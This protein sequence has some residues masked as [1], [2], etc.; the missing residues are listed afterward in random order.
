MRF[1]ET[2]I[3]ANAREGMT[4]LEY[5][6][7]THGARKGL[8]DTALKTADSGYLT[9]KLADVAQNVFISKTD[10]GTRQGISKHAIYKGE[11]IDIPLSEMIIGRI[12][13]ETITNPVTDQVIVEASKII[14]VDAASQIENLGIDTVTVRSPLTCDSSHGICQNCYGQD[15][16]TGRIVEEGLAVGIV[17]AQSIGEPGTQLTMRTFH[18]GGVA[19]TST[20]E[21]SYK[22]SQAGTIE[23]RD[24]NEVP[25]VDENGKD[26][27]VTL[28]RNGEIYV[29]DA[30][31]RELEKFKVQYGAFIR[32]EKWSKNLVQTL[33]LLTG[34]PTLRRFWQK[35][36]VRFGLRILK[37][38]KPFVL[39]LRKIKKAVLS[40]LLSSIKA[41][42]TPRIV[43]EGED[44]KILDFH[45]LPAKARIDVTEGLAIKPGQM[46]ARQ[47]REA[48]G[49][50]D[51]VGGLPRVTEIFEARKP[52]DAAVMAEISGVV[53]LK[54]DRRKGKMTITVK[55][56]AG[57]EVEQSRS[58]G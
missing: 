8:A 11:E 33:C 2:P 31:G 22:S 54:S 36:V 39:S 45:Y 25:I 49:S 38:V 46:L 7:S 34:T 52:K 1:I 30:K 23:I 43:I 58:S 12:S 20:L 21:T 40:L 29:L 13:L 17:A 18:T 41:R 56:D 57:L 42:N 14:S 9:R 10:C 27:L 4:V 15:L 47:P 3:K 44:G 32:R 35:K 16:S 19:S 24:A 37:K 28:K 50:A 5:F 6:S 55:S 51:I 48:S 53:E 26:A